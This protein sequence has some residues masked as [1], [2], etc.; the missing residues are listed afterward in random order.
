MTDTGILLVNKLQG[1]SSFG[2]VKKVKQVLPKTKIGHGGTLDPEAT[3]LLLLLIGPAT[4]WADQIH[5][6]PKTY[7]FT[8]RLGIETDTD[9]LTGTIT[10][11]AEYAHIHKDHILR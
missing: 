3:G 1:I 9:D 11:K 6:L 10:K 2:V 4:K 5:A 8:M 7:R